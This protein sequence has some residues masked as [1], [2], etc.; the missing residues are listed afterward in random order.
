LTNLRIRDTHLTTGAHLRCHGKGRKD[1]CT[2]LTNPTTKI[3]RTW[4]KE[5]DGQATDPLFPTR[6]GTPLSPDA[7]ARLPPKHPPP[8]TAACPPLA[9]KTVTPHTLRHSTAMA[10]LHAGVDISVIA[11]WLGHEGTETAQIYLHADMTIKEHALARTNPGG[12][13][14][15]RY[16]APDTL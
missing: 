1:R 11:L 3:L 2:P 4:L 16:T 12:G 13:K 6:R 9:D 14:L 7:T 15:R 5:R 8:A 10:L